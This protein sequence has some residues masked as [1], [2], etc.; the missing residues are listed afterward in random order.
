M[1]SRTGG[2][3]SHRFT[4]EGVIACLCLAGSMKASAQIQDVL[5]YAA[6][7]FFGRNDPVAAR[8][9]NH[10]YILPSLNLLRMARVRLDMMNMIFQQR[11]FIRFRYIRYWLVDSSPQLGHNFLCVVEDRIAF[12]R[13]EFVCPEY[14]A[15]FNLNSGYE[16]RVCQCSTLGYG[17]AGV[18]KKGT[19]VANL[20]LMESCGSE[21]TF[22][23]LR[24]EFRGGC[25]DTG[26]EKGIADDTVGIIPR[27]ART[28]QAT[29][30]MSFMWPCLLYI[31]GHLHIL[32]NAFEAA[33]K[34]LVQF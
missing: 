1:S 25:S 5:A 9:R 4:A 8:L 33:V 15:A 14:R 3:I 16:T 26:T 13:E 17:N 31:P 28:Y 21:D 30:V 7:L 18:V 29:D 12:P 23:S 10:E 19:N 34:S 32:F 22:H 27:F 11:L 2:A 6:A 24:S 20:Y